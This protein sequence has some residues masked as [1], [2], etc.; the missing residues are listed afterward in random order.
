MGFGSLADP[1]R[2]L[3]ELESPAAVLA[4]QML[5]D[6]GTLADTV[7]WLR[8]AV[9]DNSRM[10]PR[11]PAS[12]AGKFPL[13]TARAG[14]IADLRPLAVMIRRAVLPNG[15]ISDD[16][17]PELRRIRGSVA[18][19][20]DTVRKSLE[21]ML[22]AR[23]GDAGED[24]VT[25]RN[26]RFVIPV[27]AADRRQVQGVVHAASATGQ[28]VFVEPFETIE[29]NNRLVQLSEE[30]A[31]EI[32][33]ILAEISDRLRANLGPLRFAVETIA[34]LDSVFARARFAREFDATLPEFTTESPRRSSRLR[35]N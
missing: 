12:A 33:R 34:E 17:S 2:W 32:A 13:L 29:F 22:R 14:A 18:H 21:R 1:E 31:A 27:R 5:L 15:E 35:S 24:Y 4:P 8:D 30:E 7:A 25:L 9:R 20:R 11:R 3:A 10:I 23:G 28:T 26:D 16:A 6:A 19:T